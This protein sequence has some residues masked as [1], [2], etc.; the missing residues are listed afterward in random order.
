MTWIVEG[1]GEWCPPL[2]PTTFTNIE[3]WS[4][5]GEWEATMVD[6]RR[7]DTGCPR[8]GPIGSAA[9]LVMSP[10]LMRHHR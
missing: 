10:P 6:R 5:D 1:P 9:W 8:P 2:S 7:L 3:V 4:S